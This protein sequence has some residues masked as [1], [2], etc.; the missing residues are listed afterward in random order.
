MVAELEEQLGD[1]KISL[2]LSEP[3]REW[4][5]KNGYNRK[6]GA[7]PMARLIDKEIRRRLADDILFGALKEGGSARVDFDAD[8]DCLSISVEA[9]EAPVQESGKAIKAA[10]KKEPVS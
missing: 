1:K 8:E 6:F 9:R 5:G 10:K 4:L 2:T 3:A 7:R